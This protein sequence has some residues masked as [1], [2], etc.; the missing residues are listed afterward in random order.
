MALLSSPTRRAALVFGAALA[1]CTLFVDEGSQ[2]LA[3]SH[4][5]H[6]VQEELDC[7]ICH[8]DAYAAD[9]PGMPY[10]DTCMLCHEDTAEDTP[11]ERR[12]ETLFVDETYAAGHWS[13]LSDEVIFSHAAHVGAEIGC[14]ECHV[15]IDENERL[16]ASI[17]VDMRACTTCHA[18]RAQPN[19][20]ATCHTEVDEFWAPPSHA[21]HWERRHGD[22]SRLADPGSSSDCAT[23]HAPTECADCHL[24]E[25]PASHTNTFRRRS[26]GLAAALDRESC[27]ACH[28]TDA[29]ESCHMDTRPRSH[30]GQFGGTKSRHCLG[31]H[32]PVRANNCITCHKGA[33]SHLAA[34]P[35]PEWHT[36]GMNCRQCHGISAPLP[37]VDKGD[38]CLACHH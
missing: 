35:M 12:I 34:T 3:F 36:P 29:C 38:D 2:P 25:P 19:E 27:A 1:G 33:P 5:V 20:C 16:D 37:H 22:A 11:P 31:C 14:A 21:R 18:A 30:V 9:A 8:E 6:V 7:V 15:G 28:R 32:L 10:P 4:R 13:A 26:H 17:G 23:C 24:A